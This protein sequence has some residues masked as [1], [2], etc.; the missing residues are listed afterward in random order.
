MPTITIP[1]ETY[2]RLATRA[3][4]IGTTIEALATP[5]LEEFAQQSHGNGQPPSDLS[6]AEWKQ[7][8]D[9]HMESIETRADRY[10]PGHVVDASRES[11]YEGCGE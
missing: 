9:A 11:I 6:Y 7:R 1:E 10:P 8:F 3:A 2:R 5:V 4:A